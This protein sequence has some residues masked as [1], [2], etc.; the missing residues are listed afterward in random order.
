MYRLNRAPLATIAC[1]TRDVS[2]TL[3][4]T[5]SCESLQDTRTIN[6]AGERGYFQDPF[7]DPVSGC[8]L[9]VRSGDL[10][11]V[12][13]ARTK[14]VVILFSLLPLFTVYST[15]ALRFTTCVVLRL[16]S[17]YL[18]LIHCLGHIG[19]STAAAETLGI[20]IGERIITYTVTCTA[21]TGSGAPPCARRLHL[22]NVVFTILVVYSLLLDVS[23]NVELRR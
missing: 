22:R 2:L 15:H 23:H 14:T 6:L 3:L 11:V 8:L 21:D 13:V 19:I 17:H 5:T 4:P 18:T 12:V 16:L 20:Q 7:L 9:T 10:V 1:C